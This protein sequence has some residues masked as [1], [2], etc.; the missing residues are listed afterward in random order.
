MATPEKIYLRF[1]VISAASDYSVTV[2]S[3]QIVILLLW[4]LLSGVQ[5]RQSDEEQKMWQ[6]FIKN[7]FPFFD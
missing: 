5:D 6:P 7:V 1:I 3:A 4:I 2:I